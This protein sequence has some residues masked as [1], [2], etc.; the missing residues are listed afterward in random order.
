MMSKLN[1]L[2]SI[3]S[4]AYAPLLST[5]AK[6][7]S[8]GNYNA[9][10]GNPSNSEVRF[11]EM[12]IDEVLQWQADYIRQGSPSSAV[13]KY[14]I[15]NTTLAE[16]V[17]QQGIDRNEL[18]SP[19]MQDRLAIALLERRGAKEYAARKLTRKQF[20]ASIA[21]EWAGLPSMTGKNPERSYYSGDSLNSSTITVEE[22]NRAIA[23]FDRAAN[24]K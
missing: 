17:D 9:Y 20:A 7:E 16:L 12:T 1:S 19:A 21:K 2:P 18:F 5:I 6:G 8:G 14:Q 13:G 3:D 11:T 10:F 15:V 22:V 23:D 4:A 24:A